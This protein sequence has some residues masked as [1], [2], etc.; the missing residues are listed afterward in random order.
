MTVT[1]YAAPEVASA[2]KQLIEKHHQHLAGVP[3]VY[4]FR[5]HAA[6]SKGRIVLG[7]ARRVS[8]LNAF[9]AA[10]AAG[11]DEGDDR[12]HAFFVMEIALDHWSTATPA[13]QLALVDHELCHFDVDE[14]GKL[15]IA[16]HDLEEFNAVV[17]RHGVWRYD[18]AAFVNA[19]GS[20][21]ER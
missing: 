20:A 6:K 8:G 14:E 13:E 3:I 21:V 16:G 5:S 1:F 9:L 4:V 7:R 11:A 15:S 12:Q 17:E 19:C 18:V 2:A 10:L